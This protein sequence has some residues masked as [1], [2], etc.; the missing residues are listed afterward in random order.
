MMP[1]QFFLMEKNGGVNWKGLVGDVM[2]CIL[3]V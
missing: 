1:D 2:S 3:Q